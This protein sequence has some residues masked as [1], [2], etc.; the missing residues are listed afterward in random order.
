MVKGFGFRVS[1]SFGLRVSDFGFRSNRGVTPDNIAVRGGNHSC[2]HQSS[3]SDQIDGFQTSDLPGEPL[4]GGGSVKV[5]QKSE[6]H[7]FGLDMRVGGRGGVGVTCYAWRSPPSV[8]RC[9]RIWL[10]G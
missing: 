3:P 8:S 6:K 9:P 5:N 7:R 4:L 1:G 2:V 10:G